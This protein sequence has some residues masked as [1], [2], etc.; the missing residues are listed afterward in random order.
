MNDHRKKAKMIEKCKSRRQHFDMIGQD[1]SANLDD[2][3]LL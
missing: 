1:G 2:G 3:K